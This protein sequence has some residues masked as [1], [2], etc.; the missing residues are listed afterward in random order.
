MNRGRQ[1]PTRESHEEE[2]GDPGSLRSRH[3]SLRSPSTGFFAKEEYTSLS[4]LRYYYLCY[5]LT[6]AKFNLKEL[7]V[8]NSIKEAVG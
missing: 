5:L 8:A 3:V 1:I 2:W 7:G 6:A 4:S